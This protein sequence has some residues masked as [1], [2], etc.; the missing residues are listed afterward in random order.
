MAASA[1]NSASNSSAV[2]SRHYKPDFSHSVFVSSPSSGFAK[3]TGV[4]GVIQGIATAYLLA[5]GSSCERAF[6]ALPLGSR[7]PWTEWESQVVAARRWRPQQ[8]FGRNLT[9]FR[10]GERLISASGCNLRAQTSHLEPVAFAA[11]RKGLGTA[12]LT[13]S[14]ALGI[15]RAEH[16]PASIH[17]LMIHIRCISL[18]VCR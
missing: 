5:S 15:T 7:Q 18:L 9:L 16:R 14:A 10:S 6:R 17:R 13:A 4:V 2:S 1:D 3:I 12:C 8:V 11:V